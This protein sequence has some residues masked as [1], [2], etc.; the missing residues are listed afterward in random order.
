MKTPGAKCSRLRVCPICLFAKRPAAPGRVPAGPRHNRGVQY[1]DYNPSID[2]PALSDSDLEA[3]DSL[4]RSLPA[5]D[6]M[7]IEMLDGYLVALTL[8]PVAIA[9]RA[10]TQWLPAIWGGDGAGTAPFDSQKQRKRVALQ[11]LQHLHAI[12]M[13]LRRDPEAWEPVFSVAETPDGDEFA[14][15]EDWC[16]GFLSGVALV[17]EAWESLFDDPQLGPALVP[18]GILGGDESQLSAADL[19]RLQDPDERD[20]LSRAVA[21]AVVELARKRFA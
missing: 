9:G 7:N 15:A 21:D 4:L 17:G 16:I 2:A 19:A 8:S 5:D 11:V 14:D 10:A 6:A 12:D 1:P 13:Q 20:A 3:L 18:I